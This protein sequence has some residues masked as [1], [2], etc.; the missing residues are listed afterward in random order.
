MPTDR[1]DEDALL[2]EVPAAPD[3]QQAGA[4]QEAASWVGHGV[5][6]V[7]LGV[8]DDGAPCVVVHTEV[9]GVD[10]AS[11]VNGLPVRV[12]LSGPVQAYEAART[13]PD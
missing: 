4:L 10:V 9:P 12:E 13:D 2:A 7:G 3:E 11:T 6:A 5:V 8:T 1:S